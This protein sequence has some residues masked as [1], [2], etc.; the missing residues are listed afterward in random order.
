TAFVAAASQGLGRAAALELAR[1]GARLAICARGEAAIETAAEAI[2]AE[3]GAEVLALACDVTD[4]VQIDRA[5]AA[6]AERFGGLHVLVANAGGT[7]AGRFDALDDAAWE[8]GWRLNFLSVVRLIRAAL[9]HLRAAGWGRI[10]TITSTTVKQPVDDLL[11]SSAIRPGVVGLVRA[12]ATQLGGENIT[13]NNVAPGYTLTAR[14]EEV[15]GAQAAARGISIEEATSDITART[16]AGRMGRPDELA[17]AIA[18]LASERAAYITG[19]T[20]LVDGGA[21]RGLA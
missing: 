8:A 15:F 21:Y 20:L 6:A 13:V 3:T 17:A 14:V 7:P 2:R 1:E 18:F 16:P 12:L 4:G 9:P 11:L 5:L 10:I 19:Q